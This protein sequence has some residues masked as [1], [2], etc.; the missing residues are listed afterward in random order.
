MF[1]IIHTRTISLPADCES[2]TGGS[3]RS[4][5]HGIPGG[6]VGFAARSHG[7]AA[8]GV[9]GAVAGGV[10]MTIGRVE[11]GEI[12]REASHRGYVAVRREGCGGIVA[13]F[14]FYAS[15]G[16]GAARGLARWFVSFWNAWVEAVE[17]S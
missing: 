9:G 1:T 6:V 12:E 4:G 14:P 3:C 17:A 7:A 2:T 11:V 10:P 8:V 16:V 5:H 15:E 13:K